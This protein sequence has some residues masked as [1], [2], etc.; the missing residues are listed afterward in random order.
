[1]PA[2]EVDLTHYRPFSLCQVHSLRDVVPLQLG[3]APNFRKLEGLGIMVS[4]APASR[5]L[6]NLSITSCAVVK[7][8][9]NSARK[10][11]SGVAR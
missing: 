6:P 7:I 5:R 2:T 3:R 9:H 1:M 11:N 8:H 4:I 10:G